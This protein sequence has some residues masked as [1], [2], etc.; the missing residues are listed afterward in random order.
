MVVFAVVLPAVVVRS[1]DDIAWWAAIVVAVVVGDLVAT[2][3][4]P[5]TPTVFARTVG[6][7]AGAT[8]WA[9]VGFDGAWRWWGLAPVAVGVGV[10]F[11]RWRTRQTD[12]VTRDRTFVP[13]LFDE[14]D[15][16]LDADDVVWG[17]TREGGPRK[18]LRA[19]HSHG[20]V[21]H[22]TWTWSTRWRDC[23]TSPCSGTTARGR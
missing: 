11:G 9:A 18:G 23:R 22:G 13:F 14:A 8:V 2:A 12:A 4:Y 5:T 17:S 16:L 1:I 6:I 20:T 3:L 15:R 10:A 7:F 19:A 21:V